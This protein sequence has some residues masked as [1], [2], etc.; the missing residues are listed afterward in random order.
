[1]FQKLD[2]L[3]IDFI[4]RVVLDPMGGAAKTDE[5][6]ALAQLDGRLRHLET[7]REIALAPQHQRGDGDSSRRGFVE[8]GA[9][10]AADGGAV[11]VEHARQRAGL[12]PGFF[13]FNHIL[14]AECAAASRLDEHPGQRLE[15]LPAQNPLDEDRNLKEV[16]VPGFSSLGGIRQDEARHHVGMRDVE[17]GDFFQPFGILDR[18]RPRDRRAPIVTR[19]PR[20]LDA[21]VV[22]QAD[23]VAGEDVHIVGRDAPWF[24]G[25]VVAALVGDDDAEACRGQ[26]GDLLPP[27]NPEFGEAVQQNDRRSVFAAVGH[28]VKIDVIGLN[29]LALHPASITEKVKRDNISLYRQF[30]SALLQAFRQPHFDNGLTRHAKF[31][32]LAIQRGD[33]PGREIH[34]DALLFQRGAAG[35]GKIERVQNI[36]VIVKFLIEFRCFHGNHQSSSSSSVS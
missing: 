9:Q 33:H 4:R 6:P 17:D 7:E 19:E 10:S 27:A 8:R 18:N 26:R 23:H 30:L 35:L 11:P 2:Q 15:V 29:E 5:F 16:H 32:R 25:Q 34:V 21:E 28:D 36:L 14:L 1:M 24:I 22:E 20:L 31:A 3:L 13:I 12:R